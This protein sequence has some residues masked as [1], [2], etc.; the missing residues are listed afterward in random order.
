M[1]SNDLFDDMDTGEDVL[2]D[3]RLRG[4]QEF[5]SLTPP[6]L[7]PLG[8][9][10]LF[11]ANP[12]LDSDLFRPVSPFVEFRLKEAPPPS[13]VMVRDQKQTTT[14][15]LLATFSKE[16][17]PVIKS[18]PQKIE[19]PAAPQ[20]DQAKKFNK[21]HAKKK[22][23]RAK[24]FRAYLNKR[25]ESSGRIER[26]PYGY[27]KKEEQMFL[28]KLH[29]S[30]KRQV[31]LKTSQDLVANEKPIMKLKI[32]CAKIKLRL[33]SLR[34]NYYGPTGVILYNCRKAFADER[35]RVGGRFI[36]AGRPRR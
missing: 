22:N 33:R 36:A 23:E 16:K 25:L 7:S 28:L 13:P 20:L 35:P 10:P 11:V 5:L 1:F 31:S 4:S 12:L 2:V 18:Q 9:E 24:S 34:T 26:L 17:A 3:Q 14:S 30:L 32:I 15:S 19:T 27:E 21:A 8:K 29:K 6:P